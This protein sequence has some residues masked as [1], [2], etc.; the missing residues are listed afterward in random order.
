MEF[1]KTFFKDGALT[2]DEL[3]TAVKEAKMNVVDIADGSYVSKTKFDNKVNALS[4]QVTDLQEQVTQRDTDL[5]GLNEKLT[6]AQADASKLS[7]AQAELTG[8]Q[9]KYE[10]DKQEWEAKSARQ[11]YEFMVRERANTL[12]FTSPAA[13]RDFIGQ[14]NEKGFK[15]DGES[16]LGYDDF[17]TKYTADNPGALVEEKPAGDPTPTPPTIVIPN[18]GPKVSQKKGLMEMMKAKNENPNMVVDF[19]DK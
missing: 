3:L 17:V 15:V 19:G 16:L 14:A 13:K 8:L 12:K 18:N 6:A 4:Q 10:T 1:L 5:A 9:S 11:A 7:D 2:Y